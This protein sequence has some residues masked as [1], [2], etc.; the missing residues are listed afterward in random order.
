[1][2]P[3]PYPQ[4]KNTMKTFHL[5]FLFL[6]SSLNSRDAHKNENKEKPSINSF[7]VII[8]KLVILKRFCYKSKLKEKIRIRCFD[9]PNTEPL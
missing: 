9:K 8:C 3:I 7:F 4:D 2:L 5:N 1:M 6:Q